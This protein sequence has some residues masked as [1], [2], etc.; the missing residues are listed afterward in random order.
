MIY[1]YVKNYFKARCKIRSISKKKSQKSE[2]KVLSVGKSPQN[3]SIDPMLIFTQ[4][5]G[6]K[7]RKGKGQRVG[8][9]KKEKGRGMAVKEKIVTRLNA[10]RLEYRW[11]SGLNGHLLETRETEWEKATVQRHEPWLHFNSPSPSFVPCD[12]FYTRARSHQS[13]KQEARP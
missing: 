13:F 8:R 7:E 5:L 11:T 2:P 9:E 6:E 12:L 10:T 1:S 3:L 4:S